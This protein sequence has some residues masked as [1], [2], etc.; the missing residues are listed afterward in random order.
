MQAGIFNTTQMRILIAITLLMGIVVLASYARLNFAKIEFIN[1]MPATITVSGEGE[2]LAVPDIGRFSFSVMAEGVTATEAQEMSGTNIN[3]ILAYLKEQG[4]EEK[5]IK[6]EQYSLYPRWSYEE[7]FCPVGSYCPPGERIQDGFTVTQTVTV[8]VRDTD[9]A[10]RIVTGVGERGATDISSLAFT[11]DDVEELRKEAR[12]KAIQDAKEKAV[13]LASQ[14]G[15]Q[16][17]R[18]TW[19]DEAGNSYDPYYRAVPMMAKEDGMMS[20]FEGP[21]FPM[22]EEETVVRVN[23]TYEVR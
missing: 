9:A 17:V 14:L 21:E 19:F 12:E 1:P 3:A 22:G 8:K 11:V 15:V 23:I 6:T 20:D 10:G 7:R 2:V 13:T 18:I 16:L 4:V 5:D